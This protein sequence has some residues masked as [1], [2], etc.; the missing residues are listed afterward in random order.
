MI[1][2]LHR[3]LRLRRLVYCCLGQKLP[4]HHGG[5]DAPA[6]HLF[7]RGDQCVTGR[8]RCGGLGDPR[9][10]DRAA[11]EPQ[12]VGAANNANLF[13]APVDSTE[14]LNLLT[15][16]TVLY[17]MTMPGNDDVPYLISSDSA[18]RLLARPRL[19]Q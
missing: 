7:C 15:D 5:P 16:N 9:P 13:L 19:P 8:A 1:N 18:G 14:E 3:F 12:P 17:A 6:R 2:Q 4:F 10:S 11:P